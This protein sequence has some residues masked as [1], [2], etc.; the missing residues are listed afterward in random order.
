MCLMATSLDTIAPG[1]ITDLTAGS[2]NSS[3][4]IDLG[5]TATGDETAERQI[6]TQSATATA[7]IITE[8]DW[9]NN[10]WTGSTQ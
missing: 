3:G 6:G 1:I 4:T 5:W 7:A 8:A 9:T 2:G 10:Q